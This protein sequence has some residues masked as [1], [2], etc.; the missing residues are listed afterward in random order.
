MAKTF[1]GARRI[2]ALGRLVFHRFVRK[3]TLLRASA[4]TLT[5]LLNV[6]PLAVVILSML[7]MVPWFEKFSGQ[8]EPFIVANFVPNAAQVVCDYLNRFMAETHTLPVAT[9]LF[10]LFTVFL[11]MYN[12]ERHLNE[13]FSISK[14][15]NFLHALMLYAFILIFGP[16]FL[17]LSL[18]F[19]SYL[20]SSMGLLM[21]ETKLLEYRLLMLLS[22]LSTFL[23]FWGLY[24]IIPNCRVNLKDAAIGALV[25]TVFFEALR[26]LFSLYL[27]YFSSYTLLYGAF[28]IIPL[29]LLWVYFS[30]LIFL[31]GAMLTAILKKIRSAP[32]EFSPNHL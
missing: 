9:F 11:L 18:M 28:A 15:R 1:K 25:A 10:L 2:H 29:F 31:A 19:W 5:S 32:L 13:I 16:I 8:L 30:W 20:I 14:H 22:P 21:D 6:V 12:I 26:V 23:M 4:L 24:V 7:A 17:G 3:H 27:K